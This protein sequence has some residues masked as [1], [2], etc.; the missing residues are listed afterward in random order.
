MRLCIDGKEHNLTM[1]VDSWNDVE[2]QTYE[3]G[4]EELRI[5]L[6]GGSFHG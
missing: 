3:A 6:L 1:K 4:G 5:R 2:I